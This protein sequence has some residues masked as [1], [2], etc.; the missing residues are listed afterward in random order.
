M[1]EKKR[2]RRSMLDNTDSS[3]VKEI[4]QDPLNKSMDIFRAKNGNNSNTNLSKT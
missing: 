3:F 2:Q 1:S 4:T